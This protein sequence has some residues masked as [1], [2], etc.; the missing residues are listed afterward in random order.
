MVTGHDPTEAESELAAGGRFHFIQ[1]RGPDDARDGGASR[2]A[3]SHAV[4]QSLEKKR[5]LQKESRNNFRVVTLNDRPGAKR[6]RTATP[7]APLLSPSAGA[8]DPFQSLSVDSS[9]LQALLGNRNAWQASEPVFSCAEDL[10]FHSFRAVFGTGLADPALLSAVML[11][12]AFEAT[13]GSIDRECLDYKGQAIS[14]IRERM[15]SP[16]EAVSE[17]TIGAILLLTGVEARLGMTSQVQLHMRAVRQLLA[18][19]KAR[20]VHVTAG[21]KRAVFWQ[22]L[23]SSILTGSRR[24][25]SHTTFPELQWTRSKFSPDSLRLS[26]GFRSRAHLL[27]PELTEVLEDIQAL[28]YIREVPFFSD[29]DVELMESINNQIASIQSRLASLVD[30]SP[31]QECCRLAAYLS[32]VMLCCTPWCVHVIIPH[33]SSRLLRELL[34]AHKDPAWDKNPELLLWIL[35]MGGAF[36]PQGII[37]AGYVVLLRSNHAPRFGGLYNAWPELLAILR[38]FTWSD[39]AFM[40]Q[41]KALWEEVFSPISPPGGPGGGGP[42]P[43][44]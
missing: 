42:A 32:S 10:A 15:G 18:I 3:R 40:A 21:I 23:N 5:K 20:G 14:R 4:K 26:P 34:Q 22:D 29:G 7:A 27:T 13:G 12:L 16:R 41:V 24:I 1:V 28:Q 31:M 37:R 2:V 36:S 30:L 38:Q 35:Y 33:I 9:K 11:S 17:S 25:A 44:A 39:K 43:V 8:L 6:K 19:C